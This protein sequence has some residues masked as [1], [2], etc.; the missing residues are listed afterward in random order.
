LDASARDGASLASNTS[1]RDIN[2]IAAPTRRPADVLGM[3]FFSPAN[4]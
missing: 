2:T 1:T 4:V 3:H